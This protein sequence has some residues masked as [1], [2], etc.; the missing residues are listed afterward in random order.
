MNKR[1]KFQ[2]SERDIR[3]IVQKIFQNFPVEYSAF[4]DMRNNIFE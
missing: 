2:S 3:Y 4:I 1:N